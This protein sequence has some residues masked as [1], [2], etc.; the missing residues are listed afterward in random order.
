MLAFAM[1]FSLAACASEKPAEEPAAPAA[2][3]PADAPAADDAE[4]AG[5]GSLEGKRFAIVLKSTG[6]PMMEK[7]AE[8]FEEAIAELGGETI[9]RMPAEPT[10]DA[11]LAMLEE[12]ITQQV[13]GIAV[14]GNDFDALQNTLQKAM[15]QG[16]AVVSLD[17]AVNAESRM[18]HINQA[19][20]AGIGK[21]LVEA[22]YDMSGGSGEFAILS[23][24][25]QADNQNTWIKEMQKVLE[26]DDTYKDMDLVKIAYG[27]DLRDKSTSETEGL[28][29]SYPD[30]KVIVAP[31]T[32]GIAACAKV[33]QD[34]GL[35]DT[36][37]V[38]GLGLPSEMEEYIKSG[39]CPYMYLWNPMDMGY[40]SAYALAAFSSGQ[41]TG[42]IGDVIEAGRMGTFEVSADPAGGTEI[43]MG[44]P[45]RFEP[46]NIEEWAKIY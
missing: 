16:I 3:T 1:V 26:S 6:N 11:Q 34:K 14:A 30:L 22:A 41:G 15:D 23:A 27:D 21:A 9:V 43:L 46:D 38:T 17:S 18:A 33:V 12:L 4:D 36:I 44:A 39:A 8:G 42:E 45:F 40:L 24:T 20:A 28:I 2:E 32:V 10:V 13:D 37:K 5:G 31:T 35:S 7:Q 19:D 29:K 25:S